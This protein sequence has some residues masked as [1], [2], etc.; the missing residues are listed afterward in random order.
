MA[1]L[2][3]GEDPIGHLAAAL[4]QPGVLGADDRR[5]AGTDRVMLEATLRRGS[6]GLV[7]AVRH[8]RIPSRDNVL[9]VVDQFEELFRFRRSRADRADRATR[10]I[11]VRQAPAR[12]GPP[13]GAADLRRADDALRLHRGLHRIPGLPEA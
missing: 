6:L 13:G 12:G 7:D 9:M 1:I 3:P 8:A 11:G 10:A 2:R 4:D 5:G